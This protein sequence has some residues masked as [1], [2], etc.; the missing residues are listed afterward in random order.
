M[1]GKSYTLQQLQ[2]AIAANLSIDTS[3]QLS[4]FVTGSAAPTSNVGPWLNNGV[5]WYVWDSS[6][7]AYIPQP[8]AQDSLRFVASK[9]APDPGI[10]IFWIELDSND[11][12][13]IGV[14]S[15]FNS[16]WTDVYAS[17]FANYSTTAQMNAAI[18]AA[19]A[20]QT[21]YPFRIQVFGDQSISTGVDVPVNY[22][23]VVFD[24][25]NCIT[26]N[27][28]TAKANGYYNFT[29]SIYLQGLTGTPTGIDRQLKLLKN[30]S[31]FTR[32][33]Q[34]TTNSANGRSIAVTGSCQLAIGDTVSVAVYVVNSGGGLSTFQIVNDNTTGFFQGS[35]LAI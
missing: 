5:T 31:A 30:G 26:S 8:L 13:P 20:A 4:L 15:F 11:G 14:K 16:T 17:T 2:D 19:V 18:S 22:D 28:F 25:N 9:T 12:H 7:G 23:D 6:T 33:V 24:P 34:E 1:P 32:N 27:T 35:R 3:D 29:A 10:Y 21:S